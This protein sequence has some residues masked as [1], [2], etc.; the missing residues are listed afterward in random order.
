MLP[1]EVKGSFTGKESDFCKMVVVG[2]ERR[3]QERKMYVCVCVWGGPP[4]AHVQ[5]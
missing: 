2:E 3:R 5:V 1:L 4:G